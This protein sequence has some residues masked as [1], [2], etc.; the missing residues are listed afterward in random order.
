MFSPDFL[1]PLDSVGNIHPNKQTGILTR[2]RG[3]A[4][5]LP[6]WVREGTAWASL[7]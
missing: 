2:L 6:D 1:M 7:R 4:V 3:I 5:G